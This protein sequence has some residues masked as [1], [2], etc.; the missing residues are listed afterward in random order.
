MKVIR[1]TEIPTICR[2]DINVRIGNRFVTYC[3]DVIKDEK[4]G[5]FL[6]E[7]DGIT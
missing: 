4:E 7:V 1:R 2:I 3:R 6:L 5:N